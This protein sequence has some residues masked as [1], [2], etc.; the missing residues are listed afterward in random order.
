MTGKEKCE[1]L[2]NVRR[3]IAQ[4][5]GI[6]I[7]ERVCTYKGKCKGTCP[8]CEAD[9]QNLTSAIENKRSLGKRVVLAGA[10]LGVCASMAG[11]NILDTAID[12]IGN[13]NKPQPEV[14]GI[15]ELTGEV[16]NP[17]YGND[18]PEYNDPDELMGEIPEP[19]NSDI[20]PEG[21]V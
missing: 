6:E 8:K 2:K 14:S 21:G 15:V 18:L 10:A 4:A 12:L 13:L 20:Q 17:Y 1:Y 19:Y 16:A 11:C 5:N 9:L 7:E 3:E